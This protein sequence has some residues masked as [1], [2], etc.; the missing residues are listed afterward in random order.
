MVAVLCVCVRVLF[1]RKGPVLF[2]VEVADVRAQPTRSHSYTLHTHT[3]TCS[4]HAHMC[5]PAHTRALSER[6][7]IS[8]SSAT[9]PCRTLACSY[10][11][12]V[13]LCALVCGFVVA[14]AAGGHWCRSVL[15]TVSSVSACSAGFRLGDPHPHALMDA[16]RHV[17]VCFVYMLAVCLCVRRRRIYAIIE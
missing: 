17:C 3:H 1:A 16:V 13:C 5:M 10:T 6:R 2:Y 8:A 11:C 9:A 7:H 15:C 12:N 14:D 4:A